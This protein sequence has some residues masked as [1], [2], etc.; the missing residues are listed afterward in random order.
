MIVIENANQILT[1]PEGSTGPKKGKEMQ[2]LGIIEKGNIWI[3]NGIIVKISREKPQGSYETIDAKGKVVLPGF[4]DPHTHPVFAGYRDFEF[5]LKL[6]GLSYE[7]ITKMGGGIKYTVKMTNESS[8]DEI[9]EQSSKRIKR[10]I[11]HGTLAAEAKSGYGINVDKEIMLLDMINEL[12]RKFPIDLIPTFLLHFPPEDKER[13]EYIKEIIEKMDVISKKAK[14]ADIFCDSIAFNREETKLFL[15]NAKKYGM[16][17]RIHAD[18]IEYIGCSS[19]AL[20]MDFK[21]I[22]HALKTPKTILRSLSNKNTVF[23]LLPGTPFMLLQKKYANARLMIENNIP[24]ALGT[25]LNPNCYTENLQEIITLAVTQMKMTI[26]EAISA[27]T[28]NSAY[29]LDIHD[30]H[31]SIAVGRPANIIIAD[32]PSYTHFAYHFGVN[33]IEKIIRDGKIVEI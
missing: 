7:E 20:K 5:Y 2:D 12:G 26:E 13:S 30:K 16:K 19:L 1:I 21:S 17:L 11:E 25:D 23:I 29:S 18:E 22:D 8:Y 6:K 31:G 9:F 14:F 10:M 3:D 15:S 32:I 4:V 33:L 24:V 28:F 27:V